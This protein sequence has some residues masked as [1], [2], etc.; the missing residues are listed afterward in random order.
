MITLNRLILDKGLMAETG[1]VMLN[2]KEISSN[3]YI[4]F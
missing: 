1:V 4:T 2:I 3:N